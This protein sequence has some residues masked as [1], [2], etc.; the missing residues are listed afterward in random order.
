MEQHLATVN[1]L[2]REVQ[3]PAGKE[4]RQVCCVKLKNPFL[5]PPELRREEKTK[6]VSRGRVVGFIGYYRG[7]LLGFGSRQEIP[8]G[9]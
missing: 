7:G 9:Q 6:S 8:Q 3:P 4:M 2:S 5:S 1:I